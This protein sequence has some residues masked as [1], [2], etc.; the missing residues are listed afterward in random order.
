MTDDL[1]RARSKK[2]A[3]A[4][5]THWDSEPYRASMAIGL[6]GAFGAQLA[7]MTKQGFVFEDAFEL[8]RYHYRVQAE[9]MNGIADTVE[10]G[11]ITNGKN[12]GEKL[13]PN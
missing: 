3:E 13:H 2:A 5:R 10:P 6:G 11:E 1:K 8:V 12:P 9:I 7:E 4:K